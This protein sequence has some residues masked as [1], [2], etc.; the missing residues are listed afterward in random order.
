[1]AFAIIASFFLGFGRL[2]Q[3]VKRR[4]SRLMR[5]IIKRV[6]LILLAG[7]LPGNDIGTRLDRV[8]HAGPTRI[9]KRLVLQLLKVCFALGVTALQVTILILNAITDLAIGRAIQG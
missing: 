6:G 3:I 9:P 7:F 8:I 1:M 5:N 4:S 2:W